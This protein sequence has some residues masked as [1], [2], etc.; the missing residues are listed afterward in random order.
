MRSRC[1]LSC[2]RER[3]SPRSSWRRSSPSSSWC[4]WRASSGCWQAGAAPFPSSG[5]RSSPGTGR[6]PETPARSDPVVGV[7]AR[8]HLFDRGVEHEGA[9]VEVEP[10]RT[11]ALEVFLVVRDEEHGATT[12]QHL[13][14][15]AVALL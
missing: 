10:A 2:T 14:D 11:E 13:L 15:A 9:L 8:E 5:P 1:S 7:V 4:W 3:S 12:R 6:S